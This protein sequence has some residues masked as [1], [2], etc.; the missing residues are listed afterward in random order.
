MIFF[1]IE[2]PTQRQERIF[3]QAAKLAGKKLHGV[4][5]ENRPSS[6]E[7]KSECRLNGLPA[8]RPSPQNNKNPCDL[9]RALKESAT[10]ADAFMT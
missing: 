9:Q 7:R 4:R 3:I 5:G 10:L 6:C 8:S 1:M 2:A